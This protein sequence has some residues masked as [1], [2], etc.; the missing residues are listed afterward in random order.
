VRDFTRWT[1]EELDAW[2]NEQAALVGLEPSVER[3][4]RQDESAQ[5]VWFAALKD[6]TVNPSLAVVGAEALSERWAK[7]GLAQLWD[8][9]TE[10]ERLRLLR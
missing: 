4:P 1:D 3:R 5:D 6:M 7:N 10:T 9:L 2:L 8:S